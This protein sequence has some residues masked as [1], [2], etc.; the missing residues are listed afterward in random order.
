MP[1]FICALSRYSRHDATSVIRTLF[2]A[3]ELVGHDSGSRI[4]GNRSCQ[5]AI[6]R[7]AYFVAGPAVG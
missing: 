3:Q 1:R 2:L 6:D 7:R 5:I 4:T